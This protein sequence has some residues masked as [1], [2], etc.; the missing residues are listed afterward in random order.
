MDFL[1]AAILGIVQGLAEFLPIS[2]SGHLIL[3]PALF[4]WE[5]QGL[6]FDVGLHCGTLVVLLVYF[7]RDWV[8]MFGTGLRDFSRH[9]FRFRE[10]SQDSRMLWLIAF[11]SIPA[12]VVGLLFND[13]IEEHVRQPWVVAITLAAFG[14]VMLVADRRTRNRRTMGSISIVDAAFIGV[15]Q[16][17]AL[18]PGVSR[19]GATLC[20]GLFR[21]IR[22]DDA[23]R[24][25][26]LLGTPAF[27]GAAAL[28][29]KDLT[30]LSGREGLELGIGFL[31]SATVGFAVI[32]LLLR[33]LRTRTLLPF[34]LYRF[35]VAAL[36]LTIGGIRVI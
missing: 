30:G 7:W 18:V 8:R 9:Q 19:S 24:F 29:A 32:H 36:A 23:A 12:A 33:Y 6:A 14:A 35:A 27:V 20:A 25:A 13:W 15:A 11:G 26:F 21:D 1:R 28:T 3:V 31:C 10:H 16:A 2:S 22:R 4:G 17:M 34:V 5:D